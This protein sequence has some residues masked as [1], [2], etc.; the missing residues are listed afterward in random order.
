[1]LTVAQ[2]DEAVDAG[3]RF[4][5]SPGFN[6]KI[7]DYCAKKGVP[8]TPG[9]SSPSDVEQALEAGLDAV[10]FFPAEQAGG[11]DYIKAISAP[12]P[13][14]KFMPTGGVGPGNIAKYIAF[15]KTLACGGSWMVGA[16]LV[17][18]GDFGKITELSREA[19]LCMLGF[20]L[21][22]VGVAAKSDADALR[23][24]NLFGSM[25]GFAVRDGKSSAF[26]GEGIEALKT[27]APGEH[28]HIAIGTNSV[29]R[30]V[31]Y[32]ERCGVAFDPATAKKDANG[33]TFAIY[34]KEQI[35]GFGVHLLQKN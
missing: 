12:Y 22:H 13:S 34:L 24:A 28:G 32:L 9:C 2:V 5:V 33:D 16:D 18:A 25:F 26:A 23:A 31:A 29:F 35:L 20:G 30:A 27:A 17:N 10:K 19:V 6:R 14:L 11:L 4:I 8:I 21:A 1:V 15:R 3:A 7:V